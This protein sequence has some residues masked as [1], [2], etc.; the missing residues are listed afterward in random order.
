MTTTEPVARLHWLGRMWRKLAEL[1]GCVPDVLREPTIAELIAR[2]DA[3]VELL[4][5]GP[6]EPER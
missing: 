2:G 1:D 6:P 4:G 5:D 3:L